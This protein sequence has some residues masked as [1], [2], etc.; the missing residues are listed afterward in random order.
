M[1]VRLKRALILTG[2]ALL[3]VALW[4]IAGR[5]VPDLAALK[6]AVGS[7]RQAVAAHPVA[8]GAAFFGL[9]AASA[10]LSLPIAIWLTLAGG[11]LFGFGF[12]F[13]LV[14]T[15]ATL[16]AALAFLVARHLLRDRVGGWL[17]A[18][19]AGAIGRGIDRDGTF[20]LFT[21]RLI[22]A[23]PFFA[24][25]LAMGLTR[26]PLA[27]FVW[28]SLLGMAPATALY[29]NAGTRL[30]ELEGLRGIL[31][32][33]IA[34]SFVALG[35]FPWAARAA[36]GVWTRRR[37]YARWTR[38]AAFDRNL[39]VIGGGAAGL[40]SAYVA[41]ATGAR[42]TLVEGGAMGGDCLNRGCIPSK[43]LIRSAKLAHQ[44]RHGAALGL[45]DV[46]PPL[47]FRRIFQRIDSVI[48]TIAPHDSVERY[49]ALGVEVLTGHARLTDP[50]TVEVTKADGASSRL[51]GRAIILATGAEPLLP[52]LPGLDQV[53]A[54]TTDTLWQ[55]LAAYDT[56]PGRMLILGGG[57]VG[58][59]LAQALQ[60]LG[61]QVTLAEAGQRL[62]P[63]EDKDVSALAET[64]LRR[65][66]VEVLISARVTSCGSGEGGKW[67]EI[68]TGAGPLRVPFDEMIVAIG[69][70]ARVQ[71][72][73]LKELGIPAG[74]VIETNDYL[75]TLYPNIYVAGDAAG[76]YQL[77]NAAAHQGWHAA[78]NALFGFVRRIRPSYTN[79]PRAIFLDPEIAT[80]GLTEAEAA[81]RGIAVEVTRFDL[82]SFDRAVAD[83]STEGFVKLITRPGRGR[84][85]G[86]AIVADHA[87]DLIAELALAMRNGLGLGHVLRTPHAYP[88]LADAVKLAA[89]QWRRAH[90]SPRLLAMLT[91][92]HAF[93]RGRP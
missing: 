89:G 48:A 9:Y 25:N 32:P 44:M 93:R 26:L 27:Q 28:V 46:E 31:S 15:A 3:L 60:R 12:G 71:G 65:E 90:V 33:A 21:L 84:I 53:G 11:A 24:V 72:F 18:D 54:L 22:P 40:V 56:P 79:L 67:A 36:L 34:L 83:G 85:L 51:T 4:L 16:G 38:P 81:E 66:G 69:R 82:A 17:G 75:E 70:K 62:L 14:L 57:P 64:V 68:A 78:V 41:A 88:T 87:G 86:A 47:S 76:P 42:V 19:R 92:L 29:V 45:G 13:A 77:T 63:R 23:V 30:A 39:I 91:R 8:A 61:V 1:E 80:L 74:R 59:E 58:V 5:L 6:G 73:G 35:L 43:A 20:Y 49:A 50:W 10:A 37:A 52:D 55:A 2:L 7:L